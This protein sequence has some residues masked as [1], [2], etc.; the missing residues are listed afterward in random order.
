MS[1][2]DPRCEARTSRLLVGFIGDF[3]FTQP[4]FT[5]PE[6]VPAPFSERHVRIHHGTR[7]N[8]FRG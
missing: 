6:T 1:R 3:G 8:R 2:K 7:L 5:L 4:L